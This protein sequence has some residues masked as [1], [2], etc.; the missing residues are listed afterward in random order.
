MSLFSFTQLGI[1]Y[2][3][4]NT[5]EHILLIL[6]AGLLLFERLI[7]KVRFPAD[8]LVVLSVMMLSVTLFWNNHDI[9]HHGFFP[10]FYNIMI[11]VFL[12]L[13]HD[14][15]EWHET[16]MKMMMICGI[17][18]TVWTYIC[19]LVPDI[20]NDLV[21]P[22]MAPMGYIRDPKAGFT[23]FYSANGL[24]LCFGIMAFCARFFF[25][26]EKEKKLIHKF[27]FLFLLVGML[28]C[29]KR[30]QFLA[31]IF[32]VAVC[33]Y[34]YNSGRKN[35]RLLKLVIIF[36]SVT[37]A[38]YIISL[39]IPDVTTII[40]RFREQSLTGD[41][42][43]GRF[44]LWD[45]AWQLFLQ[46]PLFGHGWRFFRYSAFTLMDYDVHNVFLQLLTEVGIIGSLPFYAFITGNLISAVKLLAKMRKSGKQEEGTALTAL[47][48]MYEVF[49]AGICMT[50]TAL[51]QVECMFVYFAC[52]GIVYFYKRKYTRQIQRRYPEVTYDS[53]LG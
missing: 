47:S 45:H 4:P 19:V 20:Y 35:N 34:I 43:S 32:A 3:I 10:Q 48:V 12:W 38:L 50:G 15:N 28:L 31:V 22:L 51:Y 5:A 52:C 44:L 11:Y 40:D 37:A 21:Y 36:S 2:L 42:S 6:A 17:F 14:M 9:L 16:F 24:Y 1:S 33:Y 41:V 25:D 29:G 53:Q 18:Y 46:K 23:A 49:F 39:Y 30:G 27:L 26:P 13:A 8:R 7:Y